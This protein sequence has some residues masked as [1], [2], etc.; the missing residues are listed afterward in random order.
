MED[1]ELSACFQNGAD[2]LCHRGNVIE[3]AHRAEHEVRDGGVERAAHG[4]KIVGGI[5][6]AEFRTLSVSRHRQRNH[7][8]RHIDTEDPRSASGEKRDEVAAAA[9]NVEHLRVAKHAEVLGDRRVP[10]AHSV[11]ASPT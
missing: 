11:T 1:D 2:L 5:D 10:S 4:G 3:A 6:A 7:L 8:R 9:A